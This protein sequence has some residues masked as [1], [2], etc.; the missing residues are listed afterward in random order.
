MLGCQL[1]D[2]LHVACTLAEATISGLTWESSCQGLWAQ[3]PDR[4][5]LSVPPLALFLLL[6]IMSELNPPP[7]PTLTN[8]DKNDSKRAQRMAPSR[9]VSNLVSKI[10]GK[11]RP[12]PSEEENICVSSY[13]PSAPSVTPVAS[14]YVP[15]GPSLFTPSVTPGASGSGVRASHAPSAMSSPP[16]SAPSARPM[17]PP[18]SEANAPPPP[19]PP[20]SPRPLPVTS[21]SPAPPPTSVPRSEPSYS[22]Q[23]YERPAI[24]SY[25]G[26][27]IAIE[28]DGYTIYPPRRRRIR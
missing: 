12:A 27:P 28:R 19:E 15:P 10:K 21:S 6:S 26:L 16:A 8:R 3:R 13:K 14:D 18:V 20:L 11:P 1:P 7:P 25:T 5:R 4:R 23:Y 22:S 24:W 9:Y 2:Y 17:T